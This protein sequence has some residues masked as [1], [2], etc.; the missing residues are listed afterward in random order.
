MKKLLFLLALIFTVGVLRAE[1]APGENILINGVFDADEIDQTTG[2]P[3]Q[4]PTFWN[5]T[6]ALKNISFSLKNAPAGKGVVKFEAPEGLTSPEVTMRQMDMTL[7]PGGKYRISAMVK[8]KGFKS[9]HSGITVYNSGWAIEYG[10]VAFPENQDWTRM[11]ADITLMPSNDNWYGFALFACDFK[12]SIEIADVKMEAISEDALKGSKA[13]ELV[14]M[15]VMP[16]LIPWKPLL[17]N[18]PLYAGKIP[19]MTFRFFG[20]LLDGDMADYDVLYSIN[21]GASMKVPLV[22]LDIVLPLSTLKGPGDFNLNVSIVNRKSGKVIYQRTHSASAIVLPPTSDKG[23][24]RLNN[25][26]VEILNAP[27]AKSDALQKFDFCTMRSGWIFIAAQDAAADS[28]EIKL[29]G[30]V[31]VINAKTPRLENF[32]DVLIGGHTLE[33][34]G[35]VNGGKII[36]RSIPEIFNYCP[37]VNSGVPENPKYDWEFQKKYVLPAVT[38]QNGGNIPVENRKEFFEAGYKWIANLGTVYVKSD[39]LPQRLKSAAGMTKPEYQGVS[40]DEQFFNSLSSILPYT[41][42]MKKFVPFNDHVIYTWITGMPSM[43]GLHNEFIAECLNTCHGRGRLISE[44]YCRTQETLEEAKTYLDTAIVERAKAYKAFYPDVLQHWGIILG[45][46]NQIPILS[47]AHHS[48]VDYKYYLDLQFNYLANHP[49]CKDMAITGYWGSYYADHE[50][51]RWAFMLTRHYCVEGKKTMLS[52]E[53]GLAYDPGHLKNGDFDKGFN[54]WTIKGNITSGKHAGFAAKSHNRWGGNNGVGDTFAVFTKDNDEVST[55]TQVAKGLV[56]GK[57]YCLQFSKVDYNDVKAN[58]LNP[59]QFGIDVT[60]GDGADIRKDLSWIH[61]DKREKGR[62]AH[63]NN[64]ARC[65]LHHLVFIASKPE[66]TVTFDNA[67]ALKG[68]ALGLN[69]VMLTPFILEK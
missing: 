50:L 7:V 56:P 57:A 62:Y 45:D 16:R 48:N 9:P 15:L 36:V 69:Y 32:R 42:G 41:D 53:Y 23:H 46:F 55:V 58:R 34:K 3:T 38:T 33:V 5:A 10:L 35:A 2:L 66:I 59:R 52:D 30:K 14:K 11:Q 37:G 47:L 49:E 19:T 39:V 54:N 63:N 25:L 27:L 22:S 68:E 60:L 65:N 18:I 64:V 17:N 29:D 12:G 21:D 6:G 1:V 43:S 31:T 67:K 8:T 51:H 13:S 61:V 28:L 26:V 44:V 4:S 20:K 40:C 24:V